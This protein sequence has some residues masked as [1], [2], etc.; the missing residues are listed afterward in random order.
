MILLKKSI[1]IL[2]PLDGS[3]HKGQ[4]GRVGVVG[5]SR[6]YTGAPFFSSYA[7]L[8]LGADLSHVICDP[9]ASTVIKTYSPDLIVHSFLSSSK[10]QSLYKTHQDEFKELISRLHVL[11]IGPGLGRD[12]E[13]QDW[14][15]FAIEICKE[16]NLFIVLDADALWLIQSDPDIIRNYKKAILTP[17]HVEFQRL[18]KSCSIET[19][20]HQS[21]TD[22]A[23]RLSKSLGGC[24]I[25]QKGFNDIIACDGY[26]SII[27][28]TEGSPKRCGGQGDILSGLVG[29]WLAWGK[30][31]LDKQ[32]T[33]LDQING[34]DEKI[35][36][37]EI[38]LISA[39]LGSK[40]TR[41]CSNLAFDQFGRSMQT[42]DM[43]NFINESFK[44]VYKSLLNDEKLS[45]M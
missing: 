28:D 6:D 4:S 12:Q 27:I 5:G 20:D 17:N 42:S 36:Q 38:T 11:V 25:L 45:K 40:I 26:D 8:R 18:L 23:K 41:T 31:Y 1:H 22:L 13:M 10:D 29:T 14:A 16:L 39:S 37:E 21:E 7:A 30:L 3:L 24:T 2:P 9:I 43:L 15:K 34:E 33:N 32:T 44:I 35:K 19:T